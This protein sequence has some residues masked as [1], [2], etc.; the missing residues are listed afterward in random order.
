MTHRP[1]HVSKYKQFLKRKFLAGYC[2]KKRGVLAQIF[3]NLGE[4]T[5]RFIRV[6]RHARPVARSGVTQ[7]PFLGSIQ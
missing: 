1:V 4:R 2:E 3:L 7:L 5:M 6:T